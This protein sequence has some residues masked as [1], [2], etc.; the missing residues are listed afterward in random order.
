MRELATDTSRF[1]LVACH[2]RVWPS[3][4]PIAKNP[5]ILGQVWP[6]GCLKMLKDNSKTSHVNEQEHACW[7][8]FDREEP[9]PYLFFWQ[10]F[11][12]RSSHKSVFYKEFTQF[13]SCFNLV[14]CHTRVWPSRC[15]IAKNPSIL[16]QIWPLGCLK[17]LKDNFKTSHVNEK[18]YA[19][20][21]GFA[22]RLLRYFFCK[23]L[24]AKRRPQIN[25]KKVC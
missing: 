13:T 9:S 21:S 4:C 3:R 10:P 24:N 22:N 25:S 14:E 6:L 18:D 7:P 15:P 19:C 23:R 17:M 8:G 20:W 2:T 16:G 1:N 5:S 12:P 11:R